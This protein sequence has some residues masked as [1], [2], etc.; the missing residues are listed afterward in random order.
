MTN[1]VGRPK[2]YHEEMVQRTASIPKSSDNQIIETQKKSDLSW[3][4]ALVLTISA[5]KET[6][7]NF[8]A[9]K[10]TTMTKAIQESKESLENIQKLAA[11]GRLISE[12][13]FELEAMTLVDEFLAEKYPRIVPEGQERIN[14]LEMNIE[15][16]NELIND[17]YQTGSTTEDNP[18]VQTIKE[19]I[20]NSEREIQKIK[21]RINELSEAVPEEQAQN[22]SKKAIVELKFWLAE[23]GKLVKNIS[24][25]QYLIYKRL[26]ERI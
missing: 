10:W 8:L 2:K 3:N 11:P 5:A 7:V 6:R 23:R 21:D 20:T 22:L 12:F 24:A 18:V 15:S 26:R 1:P 4:E 17:I 14:Q 19:G 9:D 16:K 13:D 25:L